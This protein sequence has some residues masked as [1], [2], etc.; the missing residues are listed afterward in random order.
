M[1]DYDWDRLRLIR[2]LV[3]GGI[4]FMFGLASWG[5]GQD[6]IVTIT[7]ETVTVR[8]EVSF[9]AEMSQCRQNFTLCSREC[10]SR[11]MRKRYATEFQRCASR[12]Q[13]RLRSP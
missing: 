5:V 13:E 3:N 1:R 4:V 10:T 11:E 12:S 2:W 9:D 8:N 6:R 7:K